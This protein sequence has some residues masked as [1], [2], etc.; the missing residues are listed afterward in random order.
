MPWGESWRESFG[1]KLSVKRKSLG[2]GKSGTGFCPRRRGP[3]KRTGRWQRGQAHRRR[4]VQGRVMGRV[5]PSR[6]RS[7]GRPRPP[8]RCPDNPTKRHRIRLHFDEGTA[9][10]MPSVCL[11]STQRRARGPHTRTGAPYTAPAMGTGEG[12]PF[13]AQEGYN[14]QTSSDCTPRNAAAD[15]KRQTQMQHTSHASPY[16]YTGAVCVPHRAG[17]CV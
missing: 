2:T 11:C 5:D 8:D 1:S 3:R 6:A 9:C 17:P 10:A 12:T 13:T 7:A 4:P 14:V 15:E 16:P